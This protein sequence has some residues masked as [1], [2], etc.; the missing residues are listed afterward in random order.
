MNIDQ[1]MNKCATDLDE[2]MSSIESIKGETF[3]KILALHIN[4]STLVTLTTML[5]DD[6][7]D[8]DL[9]KALRKTALLVVTTSMEMM[10][11]LAKISEPDLKELLG[12]GERLQKMIESNIQLSKG[13]K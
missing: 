4:Y 8:A 11:E 13:N 6:H 3:V 2:M 10:C 12:W 9:L 1:A 7:N 5:D